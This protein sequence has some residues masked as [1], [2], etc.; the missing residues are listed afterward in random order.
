MSSL[1]ENLDMALRIRRLPW[2]FETIKIP[3]GKK[4]YKTYQR[5]SLTMEGLTLFEDCRVYWFGKVY[6]RSGAMLRIL[7]SFGK[8]RENQGYE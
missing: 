4:R 3:V 7:K 8:A 2:R 6:G 5:I 1:R